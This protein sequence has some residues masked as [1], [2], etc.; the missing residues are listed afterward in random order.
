MSAVPG[1][2]RLGESAARRTPALPAGAWFYF[3]AVVAATI[4]AATPLIPQ[5][6]AR[7]SGWTAFL[8][9]STCA[10]VA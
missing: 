7:T 4:T 10:A 2:L 8:I 9:L 1:E 6:H 3:A 5:I